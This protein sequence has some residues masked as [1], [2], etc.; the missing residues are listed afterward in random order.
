MMGE[1]GMGIGLGHG[2]FGSFWMILVWLLPILLIVWGGKLVFGRGEDRDATAL[3][4]LKQS[5]ARGE[6]DHE[7]FVEK[8]ANIQKQ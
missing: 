6:I 8:K 1:F 5:Y 2:L 7:Q 4:L 3:N